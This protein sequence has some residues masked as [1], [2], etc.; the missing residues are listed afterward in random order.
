MS[1]TINRKQFEFTLA[2][3]GLVLIEEPAIVS[4]AIRYCGVFF[5]DSINDPDDERTL[6]YNLYGFANTVDDA[7]NEVCRKWLRRKE[8]KGTIL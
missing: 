3:E 1:N 6:A 5:A 8:S 7:Y 4:G 2:L